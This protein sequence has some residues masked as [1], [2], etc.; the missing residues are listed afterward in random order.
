METF[1]V[2]K[3]PYF[4][5][6]DTISE[7]GITRRQLSHWESQGL[8]GPELGEDSK[9]YTIGDIRR[10]KALRY[11]IVELKLPLPFVKELVS[12]GI[13]RSVDLSRLLIETA[14][15][16]SESDSDLRSQALDFEEGQLMSKPTL[17]SSWWY[18]CFAVADEEQVQERV[19][20][21]LLLLFRIVRT[22]LSTPAAFDERKS[23]IFDELNK[24]SDIA[25]IQI[26]RWGNGPNDLTVRMSPAFAY[27]E[28]LGR[29]EIQDRFLPEAGRLNPYRDALADWREAS[30]PQ[31][32]QY[33]LRF[34]DQEDLT[35]LDRGFEDL[36]EVPF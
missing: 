33:Q 13:E 1:E 9:K 17:A 31:H 18:R 11:L 14:A 29:A 36:N 2:N 24:L 34:W 16:F 35:A 25:R 22:R 19:Y 4:D 12:S 30:D 26:I 8:M 3:I 32:R 6:E 7:V 23:E 15:L 21:L 20:D 28:S 5:I 27:E 10:L